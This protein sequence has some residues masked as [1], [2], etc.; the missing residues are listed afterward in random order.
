MQ[1]SIEK[2][3]ETFEKL[4]SMIPTRYYVVT[5]EDEDRV[6]RL[7]LYSSMPLCSIDEQIANKFKK[8]SKKSNASQASKEASKKAKRDKVCLCLCIS[9]SL[10]TSCSQLDP[11]KNA[12]APS[13]DEMDVDLDI[14]LED[15]IPIPMTPPVGTPG[16]RAKLQAKI[17]SLR[18][19]GG[20]EAGDKDELLEER[21]A[22]RAAMRE[23]RRK[24]TKEKIR[25]EQEAKGKK[26]KAPGTTNTAKVCGHFIILLNGNAKK[27]G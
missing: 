26:N 15:F 2:H 8:H 22:Q 20:G 7:R 27:Y 24:E 6:C 14:S 10:L 9:P 19:G 5:E 1:A 25:K 4:L 13:D 18:S 23:R 12:A 11:T 17:Q 21:R 3:N 16:L